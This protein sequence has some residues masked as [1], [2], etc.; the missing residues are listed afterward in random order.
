MVCT[1]WPS[2]PS[3]HVPHAQWRHI[4]HSNNAFHIRTSID[5]LNVISL[6]CVIECV[7]THSAM[8]EVQPGYN[9]KLTVAVVDWSRPLKKGRKTL[10]TR[11]K[12]NSWNERIKALNH[13]K[14][15][16]NW[17]VETELLFLLLALPHSPF[18]LY[19]S[20]SFNYTWHYRLPCLRSKGYIYYTFLVNTFPPLPSLCV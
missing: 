2:S 17:I 8:K 3:K 11:E 12:F 7:Q 19:D 4:G 6:Q 5:D 14:N 15:A 20:Y 9:Q 1:V 10:T 18:S 16:S 13:D